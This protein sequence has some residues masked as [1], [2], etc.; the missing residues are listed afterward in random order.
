[1]SSIIGIFYSTYCKKRHVIGLT[2]TKTDD[3][4]DILIPGYVTFVKKP[5]NAL[6]DQ[7]W[8]YPCCRERLYCKICKDY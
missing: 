7:I 2:E 1:M 8:R 3:A 5:T 4:N 6:E